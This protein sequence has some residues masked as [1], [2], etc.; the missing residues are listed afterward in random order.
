MSV[1][2]TK[3]INDSAF[4]P[5]ISL[6]L[7][8]LVGGTFMFACISKFPLHSKFVEVVQS[9]HLLPDPLAMA[10]AL[11]LPWVELLIG[12][13]LILGILIKPSA[14]ITILIGISF[15]VANISAIIRG[16]YYCPNCFGE[17]FPLVVSQAL[18]IDIFIMIA[19]VLLLLIAG[20]RELLGFD[21]WFIG[22]WTARK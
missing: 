1:I 9:Y 17:T 18:T 8:L 11:A 5:Y 22:K 12:S 10:Y 7:R 13:Y 3:R 19:A 21:S 15:M 14:V 2:K 20:K 16:E 6:L 4:T